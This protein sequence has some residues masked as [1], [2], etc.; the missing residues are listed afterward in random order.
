MGGKVL[1]AVEPSQEKEI[2]LI[3]KILVSLA[4]QQGRD[5]ETSGR[6]Q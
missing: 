5:K 6:A 2:S 4:L 1:V 3:P